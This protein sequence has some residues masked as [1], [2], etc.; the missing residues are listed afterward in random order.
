MPVAVSV[1]LAER[2]AV[3]LDRLGHVPKE[4]RYSTHGKA[5]AQKFLV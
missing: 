5:M 2:V 4:V 3:G 1:I